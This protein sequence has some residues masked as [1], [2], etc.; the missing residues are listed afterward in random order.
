[1][2]VNLCLYYFILNLHFSKRLCSFVCLSVVIW[3]GDLNYRLFL[4]DAADV[5]RL[6]AN[7]ELQKLQEYDQ[8]RA[9]RPCHVPNS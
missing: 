4:N 9:E 2:T 7:N 8:V 5:K 6:I 3:L 1:M